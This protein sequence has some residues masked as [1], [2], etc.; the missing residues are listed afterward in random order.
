[1]SLLIPTGMDGTTGIFRTMQSSDTLAPSAN[2]SFV[3]TLFTASANATI[4]NTTT[5]TSTFGT[6]QGSRT[7]SAN[8]FSVGT[9]L[10]I[11]GGGIYSAAA[12]AP[13]NLTVKIKLGS[14]ILA[15]AT[16]GSLLSGA[17]SLGFQ[18]EANVVCQAIGASGSF[19]TTGSLDYATTS[20]GTRQFGDLNNAGTAVTVDTTSS[21]LLDVTLT[22]QTASAS[23]V[24]TVLSS[25]LEQLW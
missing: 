17:S 23:N 24:V 21:Q 12:I 25:T 16:L 4:T 13:G 1:M 20:T 15:Q 6:G 8:T 9:T 2:S 3:K 11:Q 5:E 19:V 14:T 22:W 18:F 10:R 7:F